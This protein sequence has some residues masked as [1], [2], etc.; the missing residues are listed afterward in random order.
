MIESD[1]CTET[2]TVKGKPNVMYKTRSFDALPGDLLCWNIKGNK[3]TVYNV[4]HS[5]ADLPAVLTAAGLVPDAVCV[6][7]A[8]H[9]DNGKARWCALHDVYNDELKAYDDNCYFFW[10]D[11]SDGTNEAL[12][13]ECYTLIPELTLYTACPNLPVTKTNNKVTACTS[14]TIDKW[15]TWGNC[16]LEI[17]ENVGLNPYNVNGKGGTA[18][19]LKPAFV[20]DS[21]I[22]LRCYKDS[23]IAPWS[24]DLE[25][26][27]ARN[28]ISFEYHWDETNSGLNMLLDMSG[29]QNTQVLISKIS[30]Q[31]TKPCP[32]ALAAANYSQK[33]TPA[34]SWY[35]PASGELY[36][37]LGRW[38]TIQHTLYMLNPSVIQDGTLTVTPDGLACP[39]G[40]GYNYW[41][42]T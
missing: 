5:E 38:Y 41:S 19:T 39:L 33:Y 28:S 42:S 11:Y 3:W 7:P 21:S 4:D 9:T 40:T 23:A 17:G 30:T 16:I 31:S 25:N 35:L 34:G 1:E 10:Y 14:N 20:N 26:L 6:V 13:E 12:D 2:D 24:Y 18:N 29:L 27:D 32:A 15:N 8:T 22:L 37:L 36:Y